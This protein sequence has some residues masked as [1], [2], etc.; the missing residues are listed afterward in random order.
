[1]RLFAQ[2]LFILLCCCFSLESLS[3]DIFPNQYGSGRLFVNPAFTGTSVSGRADFLYAVHYPSLT[4]GLVTNFIGYD[5]SFDDERNALGVFIKTDRIGIASGGN[6]RNLQANLAYAYLLPAGEYWRVRM[7]LSLG[8]GNKNLNTFNLIYGDQ[9]T[10]TG[11]SGNA[12]QEPLLPSQSIDFLDVSTGILAYNDYAW[13]G[14]SVFHLNQPQRDFLGSEFRVP[15]RISGHLGIKIPLN[16]SENYHLSPAMFY[17]FQNSLHLLDM[18]LF[19]E[20]THFQAG[21]LGRNI[22]LQ[23]QNITLNFQTAFKMEGFRVAYTYG[24]PLSLKGIGGLHEIGLSFAI[25]KEPAERKWSYRQI[26]IF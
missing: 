12:T 10:Q 7:A 3:Q 5:H 25:S 19:F 22:P 1:M 8:Y 16:E 6:F 9:L 15:L 26:S 13:I 17:N 14:F 24:L 20:T 4:G 11:V 21:V 2:K 18:G 23:T